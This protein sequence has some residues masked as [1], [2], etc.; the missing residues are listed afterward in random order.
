MVSFDH[1]RQELQAQMDQA[2]RRGQKDVVINCLEL[3]VAVGVFPPRNQTAADVMESE[4]KPGD[5]V[6][7]ERSNAAG[8]TI[9]YLLPRVL[10][11]GRGGHKRTNFPD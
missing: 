4:R 9:R 11:I 10:P 8:L 6:L 3:H 5:I 1:F 7:V 2:T